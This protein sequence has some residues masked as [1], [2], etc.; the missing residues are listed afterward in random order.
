M[1]IINIK[2]RIILGLACLIL[3]GCSEDFLDQKPRSSLT[4]GTFPKSENDAVLATNA[5]YN[6][7][8]LWHLNTGGFPLLD[9]MS[10]DAIKGSSPGDGSIIG[11]YDN[12][13]HDASEGSA[14][15]WYKTLYEVIRRANLV[16]N[17]VPKIETID[18]NLRQ[19][20]LAEARFLRAHYYSLLVRGFGD[21]PMV[22]VVD[23][24][25]DLERTSKQTILN[26]IIYP[27]LEFAASILPEK[28]KYPATEMGRATK[29]AAKALLARIKLFYGDFT[30][31]EKLC[32]EVINSREYSLLPDYKDVF[33]SANEH[34]IE[35]V[36]EV[37]SIAEEFVNGGS[38]YANTQ[39]VRGTPNRGWG[40]GR[41]SYKL[42]SDMV[43]AKDKRLDPSVIFL[44]EELDGVV[45][46]GDASTP[47]TIVKNGEIVEIE[48]YN[49][50]IWYPGGDPV[51]SFGLNQRII[52]YADVLLMHAEVLNENNKS[53]Q[54]L[55]PLNKVRNRAGL[56]DIT[57]TNKNE[58]REIILNERRFE[59]ALENLRFWDLVRTNKAEAVLGQYGFR[60]GKN[61]LFPIPQSEIDISQGK[62]KQNPG[63]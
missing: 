38:Q 30:A 27:D 22:L 56:P 40:F 39:S 50:K 25:L 21:V 8:R 51:S 43:L 23:P 28:S 57:T 24:P 48:C 15:R 32:D 9:I 46:K 3:L 55:A 63:Y 62:I 4:V 52:R 13:S 53:S 17:E 54:A 18:G 16:V 45:I 44:N 5:I 36:F 59:F 2:L 60:K 35:S 1:K 11:F 29:G 37:S 33:T 49:Q 19:R 20:L 42:I 34:S 47:D 14:E 12:F 26:E 31:V 7:L 6:G 61:E 58:L 41:P 10:D